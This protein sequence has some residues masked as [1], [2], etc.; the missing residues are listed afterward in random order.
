VT[1]PMV[2]LGEVFEVARGG[3][4]RPIDDYITDDADGLNWVMI[5]DATA[6]SKVIRSTKK[7][8]R[9]EGLKKTREV[10]PGDFILSNSMS[11][12]RPYIMGIDGCIHDG[13][14][15]LRPQESNVDQDFFYH[16]LGAPEV[17]AQFSSR[18]SG[19]TVKN[20]NSAIVRETKIPLPPLAEQKRIAAILDKA[21]ALRRKRR[22]AL[23]LLDT[24]T[25]S[26]FVEMFE[27][28]P[29][30]VRRLGEV[31]KVGS[32][33]TPSRNRK[34]FYDGKI[35]WVKTTEIRGRKI[36]TSNEKISEEAVN[37]ANLKTYP[38]G[39]VLV[40]MYGQGATRGRV[41]TLGIPATINQACAALTVG[42]EI[43]SEFLFQQLRRRYD[44]LRSLGRGG[45]Q[46]NLNAGLLRSFKIMV[47]SL[48]EQ[49]AFLDRI[50]QIESVSCVGLLSELRLDS[51][52]ASLQ[53]RAFLGDL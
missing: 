10:H 51:L 36:V 47:P 42:D 14:L 24:L 29:M 44:A 23:T 16:L 21:D 3:S 48:D 33:S 50:K 38:V 35:S 22:E 39:T 18:A 40:A 6:S 49:I 30:P 19:A 13:W 20:L 7:K 52:F 28:R 45:N 41:A 26:I 2:A 32:G 1:W 27:T 9:K 34:E 12:G 43:M 46:P 11:F 25:Q 37:S 5:S 17:F 53:S 4:P 15:L 31:C 8:I